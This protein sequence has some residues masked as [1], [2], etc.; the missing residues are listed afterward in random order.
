MTCYMRDRDQ[1]GAIDGGLCIPDDI[2]DITSFCSQLTQ[3]AK[4]QVRPL[5][6]APFFNPP[7]AGLANLVS[8]GRA[9]RR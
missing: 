7:P 5:S 1:P 4:S 3:S 8:Q 6:S 2:P 9:E